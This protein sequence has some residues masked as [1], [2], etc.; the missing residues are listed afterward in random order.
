ML[1]NN[2]NNQ[3]NKIGDDKNKEGL[4][5]I[6]QDDDYDMTEAKELI[7]ILE[8]VMSSSVNSKIQLINFITKKHENRRHTDT[9][10]IKNQCMKLVFEI[11]NWF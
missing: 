9:I 6:F 8:T 11:M 7:N 2:L 4:F 3:Y 10:K 5:N 1:Q